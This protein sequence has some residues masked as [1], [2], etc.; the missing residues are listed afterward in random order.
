MAQLIDDLA[1]VFEEAL[2]IYADEVGELERNSE[3]LKAAREHVL[4]V[5]Y[6]AAHIEIAE[7]GE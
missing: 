3:R 1:V 5:F 6:L 2:S 4:H 7:R